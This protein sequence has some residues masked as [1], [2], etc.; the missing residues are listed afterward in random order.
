MFD[1]YY[2]VQIQLNYKL[3]QHFLE[4][5][6]HLIYEKKMLPKKKFK[7][8]LFLFSIEFLLLKKHNI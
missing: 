8:Y 5:V 4:I 7:F 3:I 1:K 6:D 2:I